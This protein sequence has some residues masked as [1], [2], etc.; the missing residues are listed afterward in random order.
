MFKQPYAHIPW[1]QRHKISARVDPKDF[2]L[3]KRLIPY[4]EGVIDIITATLF[5]KFIDELRKLEP[6]D[7][8]LYVDDDTYIRV[9]QV[10]A[11]FQR[12]TTPVGDGQDTSVESGGDRGTT[13][14]ASARDDT[15][16]T[17]GLRE[18]LLGDAQQRPDTKGGTEG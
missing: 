4:T 12:R 13:G 8:A 15:G 5:K 7:P 18:T 2:Y 6:I 11:E 3:L 17:G 16:A 9:E 10:L 1:D 14:D